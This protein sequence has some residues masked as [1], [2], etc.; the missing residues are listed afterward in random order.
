[1][2]WEP[3]YVLNSRGPE[4]F[5]ENQGCVG[6]SRE[7]IKDDMMPVGNFVVRRT[8]SNGKT[9]GLTA[10]QRMSTGHRRDFQQF[11]AGTSSRC[12]DSRRQ[13]E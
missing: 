4:W 3:G 5:H 11:G 2:C 6:A 9:P 10:G 12:P 7:I 8:L 13:I 1:M